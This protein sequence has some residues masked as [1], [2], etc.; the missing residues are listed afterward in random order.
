VIDIWNVKNKKIY[1]FQKNFKKKKKEK[2][3][4]YKWMEIRTKKIIINK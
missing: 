1:F 2:I 3:K 4:K